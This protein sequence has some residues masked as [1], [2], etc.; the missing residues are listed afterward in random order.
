M[1]YM[2]YSRG[3]EEGYNGRGAPWVQDPRARLLQG[4]Q[5]LGDHSVA[6]HLL[7]MH[8]ALGSNT[9]KIQII[10]QRH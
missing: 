5:G 1:T 10:H 2:G 4:T 7:S 3:G 8:R 9:R 6:R